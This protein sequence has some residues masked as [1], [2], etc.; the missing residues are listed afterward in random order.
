MFVLSWTLWVP[1]HDPG[2]GQE[3]AQADGGAAVQD[4]HDIGDARV[5]CKSGNINVHN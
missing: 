1:E 2:A 5:I 3:E 4:I